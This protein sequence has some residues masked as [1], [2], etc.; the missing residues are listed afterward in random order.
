MNVTLFSTISDHGL[1]NCSHMKNIILLILCTCSG[2]HAFASNVKLYF[3]ERRPLSKKVS[4]LKN[5]NSC[6]GASAHGRIYTASHCL[7]YY[8]NAYSGSYGKLTELS[9][10]C[11]NNRGRDIA[12]LDTNE[13]R[14]SFKLATKLPEIGEVLSVDVGGPIMTCKVLAYEVRAFSGYHWDQ[15]MKT[16]CP[17]GTG[18]SGA[19]ITN[20]K[21][22][23]VGVLSNTMSQGNR[24]LFNYFEPVVGKSDCD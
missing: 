8:S 24:V 15:Q 17:L 6:L 3:S 2:L 20:S 21:N 16:D 14:S 1:V 4:N 11:R 13:Y 5:Y 23:L 12:I 9:K 19:G 18:D 22:E 7:S 10:I